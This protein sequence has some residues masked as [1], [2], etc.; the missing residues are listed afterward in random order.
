MKNINLGA[1]SNSIRFQE[2]VIINI[3]NKNIK[4]N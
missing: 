3:E 4:C 1:N 2:N